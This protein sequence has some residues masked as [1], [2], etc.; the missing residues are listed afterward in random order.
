MS[1]RQR[2]SCILINKLFNRRTWQGRLKKGSNKLT[3]MSLLLK[4]LL[5]ILNIA[6][7]DAL[8]NEVKYLFMGNSLIY[9][10]CNDTYLGSHYFH[11]D[12]E[13]RHMILTNDS[14]CWFICE[15]SENNKKS[16]R[17]SRLKWSC[18]NQG[19]INCNVPWC[20]KGLIL[21]TSSLIIK[22]PV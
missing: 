18:M 4:E 10:K 16:N 21:M 8:T 1:G 13:Q 14:N 5:K 7:G 22:C 17:S 19:N 6:V 2:A 20:N 3:N 11:V 15:I 9:N 12:F